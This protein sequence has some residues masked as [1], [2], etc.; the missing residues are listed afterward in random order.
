M[1][2]QQVMKLVAGLALMLV[3]LGGLAFSAAVSGAHAASAAHATSA[4]HILAAVDPPP[5]GH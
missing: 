2:K 4:Y 3:L 1:V 5:P